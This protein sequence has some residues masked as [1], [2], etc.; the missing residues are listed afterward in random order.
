MTEEEARL[1]HARRM[2]DGAV[3]R[4]G[5]LI[6][7]GVLTGANLASV[8]ANQVAGHLAPDIHGC[9]SARAK[10]GEDGLTAR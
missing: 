8:A 6:W 1:A 2:A 10:D 5:R 7:R 4:G 9:W 3:S